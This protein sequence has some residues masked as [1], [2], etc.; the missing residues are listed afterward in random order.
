MSNYL[1]LYL[2]IDIPLT[3]GC[4]VIN[5]Y[6]EVFEYDADAYVYQSTEFI[7]PCALKLVNM[8]Y[9]TPVVLGPISQEAKWIKSGDTLLVKNCKETTLIDEI[10]KEVTTVWRIVCPNCSSLH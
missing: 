10:S 1:A 2:P 3:D 9:N 8:V 6:N 5:Q 4:L 7:L